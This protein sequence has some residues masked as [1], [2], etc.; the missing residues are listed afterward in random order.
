[1]ANNAKNKNKKANNSYSQSNRGGGRGRGRGRGGRNGN[2]S[3]YGRGNGQHQGSGWSPGKSAAIDKFLKQR[4]AEKELKKDS[5]ASILQ[6]I[7]P[8]E[9]F[10]ALTLKK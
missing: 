7:C 2:N 5:A 1:M 9:P 8:S 4:D 3:G 6:L 10:V